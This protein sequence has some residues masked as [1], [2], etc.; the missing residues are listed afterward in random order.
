M[1]EQTAVPG[2]FKSI[3]KL[4]V[5]ISEAKDASKALTDAQDANTVARDA[6]GDLMADNDLETYRTP[7]GIIATKTAQ[8]DRVRFSKDK[9]E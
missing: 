7:S 1:A 8:K 4:D 6:V 5:A 3:P 2:A 9:G